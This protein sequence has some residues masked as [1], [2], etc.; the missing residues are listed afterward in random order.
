MQDYSCISML[1][2]Q[3]TGCKGF[4]SLAGIPRNVGMQQI[5][6]ASD[7]MNLEISSLMVCLGEIAASAPEDWPDIIATRGHS[8]AGQ[9]TSLPVSLSACP[10]CC[11]RCKK[12]PVCPLFC[13][14]SACKTAMKPACHAAVLLPWDCMYYAVDLLSLAVSLHDRMPCC[15]RLGY[16]WL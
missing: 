14:H 3:Y 6:L 10:G 12:P 7:A 16:D 1:I 2:A 5:C 11:M 13:T 8:L 4:V 9:P 15:L